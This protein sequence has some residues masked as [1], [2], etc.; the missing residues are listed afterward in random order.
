MGTDSL[1]SRMTASGGE[2][3][4]EKEKV[5]TDMDS[6]VGIAGARGYKETKW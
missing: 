2:G 3:L 4:S 1:M 6:S 5:L